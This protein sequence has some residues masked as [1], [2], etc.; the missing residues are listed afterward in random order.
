MSQAEIF[1]TLITSDV[2]VARRN[3]CL[4]TCR[5]LNHFTQRVYVTNVT[6][7]SNRRQE[8]CRKIIPSPI[9]VSLI[10]VSNVFLRSVHKDSDLLYIRQD[11]E[12]ITIGFERTSEA[13]SAYS[14]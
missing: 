2:I 1:W 7:G 11:F 14:E 9:I 5:K 13:T 3:S 10:R 8:Y 12:G 4:I 6:C